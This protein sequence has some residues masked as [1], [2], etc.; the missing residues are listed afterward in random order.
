M[1]LK[2]TA[3]TIEGTGDIIIKSTGGNVKI[4]DIELDTAS[5]FRTKMKN[6][7]QLDLKTD[8]EVVCSLIKLGDGAS[9]K[10][11]GGRLKLV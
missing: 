11:S 10:F 4:E 2:L 3:G 7:E 8:E 6:G 9:I 1:S 5:K